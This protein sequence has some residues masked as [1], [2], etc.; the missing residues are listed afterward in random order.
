MYIVVCDN[1]RY[2]Y[3]MTVCGDVTSDLLLMYTEFRP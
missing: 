1:F 2:D 3:D